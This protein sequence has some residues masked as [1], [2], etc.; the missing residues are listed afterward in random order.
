MNKQSGF[1]LIELIMVI[2]ILGILAATAIPQFVNLS[3]EANA[4]ALQGVLGAARS[5]V[6]INYA[7]QQV[8]DG[9]AIG[10]CAAVEGA[11]QGGLPGGYSI[12]AGAG[13]TCDL[14]GPGGTANFDLL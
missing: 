4:A 2:V 3:D 10:N 11:M 7:A 9:V 1:T 14:T 12:V 8:G 13:S 6:A 5:T